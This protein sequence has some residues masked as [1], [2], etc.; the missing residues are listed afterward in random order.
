MRNQML[1]EFAGILSVLV[2]C[3]ALGGTVW[4][5]PH[6]LTTPHRSQHTE[7]YKSHQVGAVSCLC[8]ST[9]LTLALPPQPSL[10]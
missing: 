2:P 3:T 6:M 7:E 8:F 5:F 10:L 9:S 4:L 1:M